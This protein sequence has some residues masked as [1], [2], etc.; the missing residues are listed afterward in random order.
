MG[1]VGRR[2]EVLTLTI[3]SLSRGGFCS[4][5]GR[6][7]VGIVASVLSEINFESF[8]GCGGRLSSLV[9]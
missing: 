4:V 6:G 9:M 3:I 8:E 7:W 2:V 5:G 1:G